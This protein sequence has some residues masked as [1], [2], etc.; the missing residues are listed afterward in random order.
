[1]TTTAH[2]PDS[3]PLGHLVLVR[4]GETEWSKSG[5]HTGLTDVPLTAEGEA[6]ARRAGSILAGRQF[7]RVISS[8]LMR[9]LNTA[10]LA[11]LAD[12]AGPA[13]IEVDPRLLE[14]DYG[15]YE[16]LTTTQI[17]AKVGPAWTVFDDGVVPGRTP[18]ESIE[19]V[20]ARTA[21]VL[22]DVAADLRDGDV[23]LVGHG[24]CLRV[25]TT[26]FLRQEPRMG[27]QILLD[28]GSVSVLEY[29]REQPAIR[30]WN[31]VPLS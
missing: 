29:E 16:G 22:A 15:G 17:R 24:H 28:A 27:A 13:G 26:V 4:H 21:G 25:L 8:P 2:S 10:D 9:A 6:A 31:H 19:A 30:S 23:A 11:G 20:A 14:W 5:Q 3:E 12:L 1:M 7:A 18:G